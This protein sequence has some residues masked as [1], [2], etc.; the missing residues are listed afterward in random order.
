MAGKVLRRLLAIAVCAAA[1]GA[2]AANAQQS[3]VGKWRLETSEFDGDC[4][5]D[6][7]MTVTP[8]DSDNVFDCSFISIQQ[9]GPLRDNLYIKVKQSC[10]ASILGS[11]VSIR[12]HVD[13][14]IEHQPPVPPGIPAE[15][16]Y[17]ADNFFVVASKN[18]QEMIGGHY[19]EVRK[20]KAR[21]WRVEDLTS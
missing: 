13:K 3:L 4:K 9:C 17:L 20:L 18:F 21:F 6:G 19:D 10:T 2:G 15:A 16:Y 7:E 14:V 5:I 1:V 12:S 11:Q 8:T